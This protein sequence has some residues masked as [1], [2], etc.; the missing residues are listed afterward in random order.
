[1][2]TSTPYYYMN[3]KNL[4]KNPEL[5]HTVEKKTVKPSVF[6]LVHHHS[7]DKDERM[8]GHATR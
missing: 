3:I 2:E 4:L 8:R 5:G 6:F 7:L 1:M